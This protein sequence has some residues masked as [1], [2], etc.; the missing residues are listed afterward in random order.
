MAVVSILLWLAVLGYP[1]KLNY[2]EVPSW[3]LSCLQHIHVGSLVDGPS[4]CT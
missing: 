4:G 3:I 2:A 1:I